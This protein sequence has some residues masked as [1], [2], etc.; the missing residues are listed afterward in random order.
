MPSVRHASLRWSR[1]LVFEG[2]APGGPAV[3]LDGDGQAGPSPMEQLL[4]AAAGCSA[5]DV[6]MILEKMRQPLAA[7]RVEAAGTRRDE[8]PKRY[9]ALELVF[10]ASGAG[11]ERAKVERAVALSLEKYCS[12]VATL[13]PDTVVTHRVVLDP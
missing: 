4:L 3:V 6:V 2:G 9:V 10:H 1:A 11:L 5:I 8:E 12:V 13:A 7:L